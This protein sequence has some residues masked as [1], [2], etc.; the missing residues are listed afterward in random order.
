MLAS[1]AVFELAG[2]VLVKIAVI[3]SGESTI[4]N[5]MK[6]RSVKSRSSIGY[7][8][9]E[10]LKSLG[11]IK[12][13]EKNI[14]NSLIKDT[15]ALHD[16]SKFNKVLK[17]IEHSH[18]DVF[19]VVNE[20]GYFVGAISY[21]DIQD[22]AFDPV[23]TDIVTAMDLMV[24]NLYVNIDQPIEKVIETFKEINNAFLPAV[25]FEDGKKHF[26]GYLSQRDILSLQVKEE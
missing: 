7:V 13:K 24:P 16:Y 11:I 25:H 3:R 9:N 14:Q 5:V 12:Q 6:S 19:P 26:V 2:P 20:Q 22:I 10:M 18:F 23:L 1:V 17:F 21:F 4:A 8:I 15:S